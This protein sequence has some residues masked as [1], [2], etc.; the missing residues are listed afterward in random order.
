MTKENLHYLEG[1]EAARQGIVL[2][3]NPYTKFQKWHPGDWWDDAD[4]A[5]LQWNKACL[6]G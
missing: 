4:E 1:R 5:V 6:S 3:Q 2:D